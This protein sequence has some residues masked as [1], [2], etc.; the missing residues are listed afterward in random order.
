VKNGTPYKTYGFQTNANVYSIFVDD[1]RPAFIPKITP[2]TDTHFANVRNATRTN[3]M[4]LENGDAYITLDPG[5]L[6]KN[7]DGKIIITTNGGTLW[8]NGK[9]VLTSAGTFT[10]YIEEQAS[11]STI[12]SLVKPIIYVDGALTTNEYPN[13]PAAVK[14]SITA[15]IYS[16]RGIRGL[17]GIVDGQLSIFSGYDVVI[18]GDIVYQEWVLK[19]KCIY[20][21]MLS[22]GAYTTYEPETGIIQPEINKPNLLGVNAKFTIILPGDIFNTAAGTDRIDAK[23][24]GIATTGAIS[25]DGLNDIFIFGVYYA[26]HRIYGETQNTESYVYA[27]NT[28]Y[29]GKK[30]TWF[31]YGSISSDEQ[32]YAAVADKS[33]NSHTG[34]INR[35]YNYD[36]NLYTFQ[37]PMT[38]KIST[39]PV[40][41]WRLTGTYP[42]GIAKK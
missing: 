27:R 35:S 39:L 5:D 21:D 32:I 18:T 38:L 2:Q 13:C 17:S 31:I 24:T 12:P 6:D 3:G 37:P 29:L 25:G 36:P 14:N 42:T 20:R 23:G 15:G 9:K 19:T 1:G 40:W 22:N 41:S 34:F 26:K 8:V 11:A 28:T 7:G 10:A 4:L 16:T 30:G 33:N